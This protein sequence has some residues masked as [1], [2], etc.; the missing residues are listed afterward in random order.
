M[1]HQTEIWFV[2]QLPVSILSVLLCRFFFWLSQQIHAGIERITHSIIWAFRDPVNWML[3]SGV[4]QNVRVFVV[5]L[6]FSL[7]SYFRYLSSY[8]VPY[9][10]QQSESE[11]LL[12]VVQ[13]TKNKNV[14]LWYARCCCTHKNLKP[15]IVEHFRYVDRW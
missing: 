14:P 2:I 11:I 6:G 3:F 7:I 1:S 12:R 13:P 4:S 9:A 5:G 8:L 15:K 10:S